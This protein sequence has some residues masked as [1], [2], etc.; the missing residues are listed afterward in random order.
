MSAVEVRGG[1]V[2][3]GPPPGLVLVFDREWAVEGDV[4]VPAVDVEPG[5][6]YGAPLS[7]LAIA[8]TDA[9]A[10]D[11]VAVTGAG[12]VAAEARRLLRE[13]RREASGDA[14]SSVIETTGDPEE[15]RRATELVA[16]MGTVLLAGEAVGR[17]CDI[18]LYPDV[19]TRGV[20]V[21]GVPR[22]E[23]SPAGPVPTGQELRSGEALDPAAL[24]YVLVS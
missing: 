13:Q 3:G 8:A 4:P 20:R 11:A 23:A 24:F 5:S 10:G 14:P 12:A 6:E 18:D 19:H 21:K 9:A 22:P 17:R 15:I 2:R 16:P 1:R 7:A